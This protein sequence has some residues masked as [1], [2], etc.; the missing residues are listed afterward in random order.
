[1][2]VRLLANSHPRSMKV[3]PLCQLSS[4]TLPC[5]PSSS[6]LI[7]ECPPQDFMKINFD[8][9]VQASGSSSGLVVRGFDGHVLLT[10]AASGDL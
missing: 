10:L 8:V 6:T 7:C 3:S 1:M 9:V 4:T 5:S 2:S